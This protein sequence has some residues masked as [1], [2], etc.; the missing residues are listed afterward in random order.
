MTLR[1]FL[2]GRVIFFQNDGRLRPQ[3]LHLFLQPFDDMAIHRHSR[4][5]LPDLLH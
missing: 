4:S 5:Q 2:T 1:R 3:I